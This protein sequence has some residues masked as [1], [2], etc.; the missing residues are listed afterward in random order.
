MTQLSYRANLTA[1]EMPFLAELQGRNVIVGQIDQNF[2]RQ[3]S[4][5]KNKDRDVGIPQVY[6]G[7]NIIP[8]DAGFTTVGYKQLVIPPTDSD[9]TFTSV[10]DIRDS[11][12]NVA[13]L[14]ITASGRNY[15]MTD[16]T[17]GWVRTTDKV[18]VAGG[19]VTVS[20]VNGQSYICYT[21]IGTFVY[22]FGTGN[23]DAVT[24]TAT[25]TATTI[26]L[27]E[28][29]GYN[30]LWTSTQVLHSST[31][32]PT[33]FTPSLIT[34]AGS[35]T[36]QDAKAAITVCLPHQTGFIIYTKRNAIAATYTGNPQFPFTYKEIVGAGG[37]ASLD[38]ISYDA[39]GTDH[40]GYTTD[41]MQTISMTNTQNVFPPLTDFL[42]G[43]QFE[44]F[45]ESTDLFTTVNLTTTML[46][47]VTSAANR[48]L[49][50]S[51]GVTSLTHA[52][53]YDF[54]LARWGKFKIPHVDCF[55][56]NII[57]ATVNEIPRQ[58]IGFLQ[59]DGT[60]KVVTMSYDTAGS[61]GVMILGKYQYIRSQYITLLELHLESIKV[62]N[63]LI[64]KTLT[65]IDGKN[66]TASTPS[67]S[68]AT[69]TYR[70]YNQRV[71]GLNHSHVVSGA[72]HAHSIELKFLAA[73]SV[74]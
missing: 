3:L 23:L 40:L 60:V 73:G 66:F 12:E 72:F 52:W 46:K 27:C 39:N 11:N 48:Y 33:D 55:E 61:Y 5:V 65:S 59:A 58:C 47:K 42:A 1:A 50:I 30:I 35:D 41:G 32:D 7:H 56:Y 22:N 53:I 74:R 10:F 31:I 67:L 21:G 13:Y 68:I 54:S 36:I 8:T 9:N 29:S 34:G 51:Y 45:D 69:G 70:R 20:H 25:N 64:I 2:S 37:L 43:S 26:G 24:L 38:L 18:P 28:A 14:G 6:Y 4:S 17:I 63:E 15:V 19:I 16:I 71:T 44:D 49:I 57:N 62:A